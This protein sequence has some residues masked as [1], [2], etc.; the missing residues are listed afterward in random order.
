VAII[1]DEMFP[2]TYFAA[3]GATWTR[4]NTERPRH[5]DIGETGY[6]GNVD[7]HVIADRGLAA[8][9]AVARDAPPA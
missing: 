4:A 6:V 2:V 8:D 9:R 7:V 1:K 5:F 3:D